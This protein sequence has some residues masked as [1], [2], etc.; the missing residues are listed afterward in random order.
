M[1]MLR[2][3]DHVLYAGQWYVV[4]KTLNINPHYIPRLCVVDKDF[5]P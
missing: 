2:K 5:R 4:C 1:L 3:G